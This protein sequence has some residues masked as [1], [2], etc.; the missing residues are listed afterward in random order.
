[1]RRDK[2]Q[3][4]P[5][6]RFEGTHL[7]DPFLEWLKG[8][9]K[10]KRATRDATALSVEILNYIHDLFPVRSV[11]VPDRPGRVT[12]DQNFFKIQFANGRDNK[13]L[14][15]FFSE[16]GY[17]RKTV[18]YG[19]GHDMG[20]FFES[21]FH[22]LLINGVEFYAV[23]W[24][25]INLGNRYYTLPVSFNWVNPATAK[26]NENDDSNYLIQRFSL[27]SKLIV[28]YFKYNDHK[29]SQ[30]ESLIFRYPAESSPVNSSMR[31]LKQLT[32]GMD[33]SLLQGQANV[34]P[35]NYSLELEKTRYRI[36]TVYWRRQN[37]TRVKIKRIFN[38]V[39]GQNGVS[40]TTYYEVFAY[41]EYKK[42]LNVMRDYFVSSFNEQIMKRIQEKNGYAT[43][44]KLVYQGFASN[45]TI[46]KTF[47]DYSNGL[48]N[49]DEFLEKTKDDYNKNF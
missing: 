13:D 36:A 46:D 39:V 23:E 44:L 30:D 19:S 11:P 48:I 8:F 15:E 41:S 31:Y 43:E 3:M 18:S 14:T 5:N 40:L 27:V 49:V 2:R 6:R 12:L 20:E 17:H 47:Q 25:K 32:Q 29:Y 45:E 35:E 16:E 26:V 4:P 34:E 10:R 24:E 38:Q 9:N 33:F 22:G 21:A 37:V 1:M 42:H 7:S 28:S